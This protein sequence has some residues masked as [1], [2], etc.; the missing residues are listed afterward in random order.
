VPDT[1]WHV[2]NRH[3]GRLVHFPR[4]HAIHRHDGRHPRG[5]RPQRR[6]AAVVWAAVPHRIH[7]RRPRRGIARRPPAMSRLKPC[8]PGGCDTPAGCWNARPGDRWMM[9]TTINPS[10]NAVSRAV[11]LGLPAI[12]SWRSNISPQQARF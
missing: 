5:N 10:K 6:G 9:K 4:L 2:E 8:P 7:E 11:A 3:P 1:P 12:F